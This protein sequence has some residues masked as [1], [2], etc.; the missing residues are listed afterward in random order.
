MRVV[1]P[2]QPPPT[3]WW[4]GAVRHGGRRAKESCG[5]CSAHRQAGCHTVVCTCSSLVDEPSAGKGL[6][7]SAD[8]CWLVDRL[9]AGPVDRRAETAGDKVGVMAVAAT[10]AR[11]R[12][13]VVRDGYS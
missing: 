9:T 8:A 6:G 2:G 7:V 11:T 4:G 10:I 5:V 3:A 13:A 12:K 1:R